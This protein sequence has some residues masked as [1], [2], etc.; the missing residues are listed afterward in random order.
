MTK[1]QLYKTSYEQ[2]VS[3]A[4]QAPYV[5]LTQEVYGELLTP[6]QVYQKLSPV[7]SQSL[8]IEFSTVTP[9]TYIGLTPLVSLVVHQN[10]PADPFERLRELRREFRC[11][12]ASS[13]TPLMGAAMG[14][15][16]YDAVRYIE[17]LPDQHSQDPEIPDIDI[18]F[19][20]TGITFHENKVFISHLVKVE[21]ELSAN[22][23]HGMSV[24]AQL[25][26]KIF[27]PLI[28]QQYLSATV[29]EFRVDLDDAAFANIVNQAKDYIQKGDVFQVVSSRTFSKNY[30]QNPFNIYLALKKMNPAPYHFYLQNESFVVTGASPEKI[31]SVRKGQIDTAPLAGT[32][33]I[34]SQNPDILIEE[35][36]QDP[37]EIAEHVMLV[38]LARNDVGAVAVPGSVKVKDY[39]KPLCLSQV[40][41]LVSSVEGTIA[42]PYDA[43]DVL[44]STFPAGTLS[45]A[46]KIRAMEII[47]ELENSRRGIYGGTLIVLDRENNLETCILIRTA[48]VKK[49]KVYIRAGAGIVHDSDPYREAQECLH[50]AMSVMSAV[51]LAEKGVL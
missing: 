17:K 41:H 42:E 31:V 20:Q 40:V 50:K 5:V 15:L 30:Q 37:K 9:M 36:M 24:I 25:I 49:N 38:D 43:I 6:T 22:Y 18:K 46:P 51:Q 23:S 21:K 13:H 47:D 34:G 32:R 4:S 1:N 45:G 16:S 19:Y 35:L 12:D 10:D 28:P 7:F 29:D 39:L 44:K 27:T 3:L 26:E 14:Y 2:F 48:V 8:L 11:A 33:A